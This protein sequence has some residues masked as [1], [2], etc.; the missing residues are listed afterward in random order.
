MRPSSRIF[1]EL[2]GKS[3]PVRIQ[4]IGHLLAV[5][6]NLESGVAGLSSLGGKVSQ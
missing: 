3:T 5:K 6:G 2:L 1:S 4:I